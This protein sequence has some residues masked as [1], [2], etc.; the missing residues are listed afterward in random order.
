[1]KKTSWFFSSK[2]ISYL[3]KN[4]TLLLFCKNG[5]T[6]RKSCDEYI[7]EL[8]EILMSE[9]STEELFKAEMNYPRKSVTELK[10]NFRRKV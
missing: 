6:F 8:R 5:V 1:M 2:Q 9:G 10:E 4:I 3:P 7:K